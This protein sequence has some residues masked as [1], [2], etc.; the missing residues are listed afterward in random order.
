MLAAATAAATAPLKGNTAVL[1][2]TGLCFAGAGEGGQECA[3][4]DDPAPDPACA[5][6]TSAQPGL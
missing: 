6:Q 3:C 5:Q 4:T 2:K 1:S